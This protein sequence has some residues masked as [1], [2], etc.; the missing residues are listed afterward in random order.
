MIWY[1]MNLLFIFGHER[2]IQKN[3]IKLK[4]NRTIVPIRKVFNKSLLKNISLKWKAIYKNNHVPRVEM[5]YNTISL[6][7]YQGCQQLRDIK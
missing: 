2:K 3:E 7:T 4:F 1:K 6:L 5:W